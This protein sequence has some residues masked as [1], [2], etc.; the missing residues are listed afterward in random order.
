VTARFIS[1]VLTLL[2]LVSPRSAL[3]APSEQEL[4]RASEHFQRGKAAFAAKR[5]EEAGAA[6]GDAFA[7]VPDAG[8]AFNAALAWESAKDRARAADAYAQAIRTGGLDGTRAADAERALAKTEAELA[9]VVVRTASPARVTIAYRDEAAPVVV[10][11]KPGRYEIIATFADGARA[12]RSIDVARAPLELEIAAPVAETATPVAPPPAP[13]PE[14][15]D[16]GTVRRV[17]GFVFLGLGAAGGATAIALGVRGVDARDEFD[18]TGRAS[19][20]LH[21]EA[22]GLRLGANIAWGIAGAFTVTGVVLVATSFGGEDAKTAGLCV[23]PT[24]L[25]L[26][27]VF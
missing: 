20:E 3:A 16:P 18:A 13:S 8:T 1:I 4:D 14:A 6:F 23:G 2:W 27:G 19:Q 25:A 17:V 22:Q 9:R 21:D 10:H 15:S 11:V 24:R 26:C 7:I 12:S 5:F